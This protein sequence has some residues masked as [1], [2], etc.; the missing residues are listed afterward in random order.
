[1]LTVNSLLMAISTTRRVQRMLDGK[2]H[3]VLC[4]ANDGSI[5]F[6]LALLVPTERR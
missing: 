4:G 1:M 6:L 2:L 5:A 3:T